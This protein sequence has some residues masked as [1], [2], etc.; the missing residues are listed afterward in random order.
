MLGM[1]GGILV[2]VGWI[3]AIVIAFKTS[4]AL[5]GILNI[6]PIQ[7]LIGIV[8]AAMKKTAWLPVGLMILGVVLS[9]LGGGF[10][11]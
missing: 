2:L 1:L 8:S 3:W 10:A 4:G 11:R 9:W 7:P 5:W 6:I